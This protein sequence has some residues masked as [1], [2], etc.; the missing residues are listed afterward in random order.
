MKSDHLHCYVWCEHE[1]PQ[2]ESISTGR[3][4]IAFYSSA[5]PTRENSGNEDSACAIEIS[6]DHLILAVADGVGG[7]AAGSAASRCAVEQLARECFDTGQ[8]SGTNSP[9]FRGHIL[10]AIEMANSE[11]QGWS[12]G[13]GTTLTIIELTGDHFRYFH[14]GD[15]GAL[16][17]SNRGMI[18]FATVGHGPVDQAVAIGFLNSAEAMVHE[19]RNLITNCLGNQDLKIEIGVSQ[20]ISARD[21]LLV[22][23]DGLF[24]NLTRQEIADI[25]RKGD[26][27]EQTGQLVAEARKRMDNGQGK[28]D[29]LTLICFR[30]S[31]KE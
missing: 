12:L 7:G 18:R 3:G 28:P 13:S 17:T 10:N 30:N 29:D 8:E 25:I 21:T 11:I 1:S 15:S 20:P 6:D 26:L 22:A 24:D 9:G 19:D 27:V 31:G 4:E 14:A 23:S 2:V 16:L 5:C